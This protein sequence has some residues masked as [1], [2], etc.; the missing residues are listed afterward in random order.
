MSCED[1][2]G[3]LSR[4]ST[5]QTYL[6]ADTCD[7]DTSHLSGDSPADDTWARYANFNPLCYPGMPFAD[8]LDQIPLMRNL[9]GSRASIGTLSSISTINPIYGTI[10]RPY[11]PQHTNAHYQAMTPSLNC[12]QRPGYVTLPRR[13]KQRPALPLGDSLGP[14]SNADGCSH[15]NISTLPPDKSMNYQCKST[16]LLPYI[17]PTPVSSTAINTIGLP[18]VHISTDE[19]VFP[20][21]TSTPK[22]E[23]DLSP[24][25]SRAHLDTIPEQE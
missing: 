21:R 19:D 15:S 4:C 25:P 6:P 9:A 22:A 3:T 5:R 1:I 8:S 14:R 23:P 18:A 24:P 12:H 10:R 13:P 11:H 20:M 17:P 2:A 16:T 7:G